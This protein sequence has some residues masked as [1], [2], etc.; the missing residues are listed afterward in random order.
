MPAEDS[1]LTPLAEAIGGVR[2]LVDSALPATVF[3]LVAATAGLRPAVG[4]AIGASVVLFLVRAARREPLRYAASG[5]LG[6]AVSTLVALRLGRAEGFFLP[7][8]VFSAG[9]AVL[10]A[11]SI[12]VRRPLVRVIMAALG[13]PAPTGA[14]AIGTTALWAGVFAGRAVVQ[15]LLYA[16]GSVGW[17]AAVRLLMGW[18]LTLAALALTVAVVRRSAARARAAAST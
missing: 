1:A 15:G 18:P 8:I 7:G 9:Y 10:F 6:V 11:G 5:V 2:G 13:R 14:V 3:V 17:L 16:A 12:L 4:V